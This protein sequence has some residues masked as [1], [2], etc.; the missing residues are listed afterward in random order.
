M[1]L[2]VSS[3][4]MLRTRHFTITNRAHVS[5]LLSTHSKKFSRITNSKSMCHHHISRKLSTNTNKLKNLTR[6]RTVWSGGKK[7]DWGTVVMNAGAISGLCG[8]MMSDVLHLRLLSICG[9][10]CGIGY[11]IT[12]SPRQINA[13]LWGAVFISTNTYMIIQLLR[14]RNAEGPKFNVHEL[15]LWQRHFKEFG[16]DAKTFQSMLTKSKWKTYNKGDEIVEAFKPL[17]DVLVIH[18]GEACAYKSEYEG[19]LKFRKEMYRYEGRG[20]NGCI[21]GG[22]ALVDPRKSGN[23]YP[24]SVVADADDTIVVSWDRD[25]L[26]TLM[27]ENPLIESAFV[28]TMYVDLITG[29]RRQRGEVFENSNLSSKSVNEANLTV[30]QD[31]S[32]DDAVIE[33]KDGEVYTKK[34]KIRKRLRK[35]MGLLENAI[36]PEDGLILDPFQKRIAR[37]FAFAEGIS[38]AQHVRAVNSLGWSRHEWQDGIKDTIEDTIEDKSEVKKKLRHSMTMRK[39]YSAEIAKMAKKAD[40]DA[41]GASGA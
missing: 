38:L 9:S 14:E 5:L 22:T 36:E 33:E 19:A 37:K 7:I 41:S 11:N 24:H 2:Q 13:C 26:K 32:V 18:E 21:V 40:A 10:L 27:K 35:Y 39:S 29:L 1:F 30:E 4:R 25:E 34:L 20:R 31:G 17:K 23:S 16:V 12:R 3:R 15:H 8:F 28:H 6:S